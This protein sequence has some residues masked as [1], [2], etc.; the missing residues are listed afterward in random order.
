MTF[1]RLVKGPE[2]PATLDQRSDDE[3][4]TLAQAGMRDAFAVLVERHAQR[5]VQVCARFVNDGDLGA[6]LA[7]ETWVAVW[8]HRAKYRGD[9]RFLVWLIT[10]ARNRCRNHARRHGVARRHVEET[11]RAGSAPS[12]NQI[13][14]LLLEE[15]RRRVRDAL[16]RLPERM[17][18][19]V[20]LRY[21]EELA[22]DEMAVALRVDE[23]TLRSRV[24]HGLRLLRSWLETSG[25]RTR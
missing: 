1:P 4:M 25:G 18:E 8:T 17:R 14:E 20:M 9:G 5:L 12:A 10:A 24:H 21:A 7:Q 13:D 3:L 11:A 15:R 19:A 16:A 22:Y 6:E 23:S 2:P